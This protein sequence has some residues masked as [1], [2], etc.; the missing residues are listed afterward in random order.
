MKILV[1]EHAPGR[2]VGIKTFLKENNI[3]GDIWRPYLKEKS[4][5]L[6]N[7]EKLIIGGGPMGVYELNDYPFL[8]NELSLIE[9][10][11]D[12]MPVLGIC[13]GAQILTHLS[14]GRIEKTFWRR[15]WYKIELTEAGN[16]DLLFIRCDHNLVSF[17]F[18]RDEIVELPK[19]TTVLSTSNNCGIEAFRFN[20]QPVWAIQFHFEID[21]RTGSQFLRKRNITINSEALDVDQVL[22]FSK[23]IWAKN[24]NQIFHNF[25]FAIE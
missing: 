15:G 21:P 6:D 3:I 23:T 22:G 14:G 17:Q 20:S 24:S 16:K 4:P 25:L 12:L 1:I 9:R 11:V 10:A 19:G 7:Y 13:L 5:K 2:V 8:Y 18:H